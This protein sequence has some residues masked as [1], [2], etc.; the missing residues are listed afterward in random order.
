M[1]IPFESV[2]FITSALLENEWPH[3]KTPQGSPLPEIAFVGRSNVGKSS[4]INALFNGKKIAKTSSTPGKTQ[5]INFFLVDEKLLLVDLPGYGY[6]KIEKTAAAHWSEAIDAYFNKREF[7]KLLILLVDS[8]RGILEEDTQV[9]RW[10]EEKNLP[11]LLILTKTDKLSSSELKI[12][13]S[14]AASLVEDPLP[15]HVRDKD[16]RRK[17]ISVIQKR[18]PS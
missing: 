10:A 11:L 18:I 8:R 14:Q 5:R 13:L 16:A 17:L 1:K 6:A 15:F 9:I 12:A 7:L 4:L 3:L 2:H